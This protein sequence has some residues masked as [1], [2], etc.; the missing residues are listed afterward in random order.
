MAELLSADLTL[1]ENG[2]NLMHIW[3]FHHYA[4]GPGVGRAYGPYNLSREWV[5]S[6]HQVTL[7]LAQFHHLLDGPEPLA[8][9]QTIDGI[10]YVALRARSYSNNGLRRILNM[11]DYALAVLRLASRVQTDITA[12]DAIII[13]SPHPFAILP[14]YW[15]AHNF[16]CRL[17]FEVRD[18]WP[19]SITEL[20]G[21]SRWHPFV[22]L[23]GWAERFGYRRADVV[24]SLLAGV[25]RYIQ[26][27]GFSLKQYY[28]A[29]NG[30]N[31]DAVPDGDPISER[32]RK[33]AG[34]IADWKAE[35]RTVLTYAGTIGPPNGVELLIKAIAVV[36][37]SMPASRLGV[38]ILGAGELAKDVEEM[39]KCLGLPNVVFS[40][41]VPKV[42]ALS[43]ISKSDIGYA[44]LIP[45]DKLYCYGTS[46]NKM[47]DYMVC[48]LP[49]L[50]PVKAYRDPIRQS[51]GGIALDKASPETLADAIMALIELG[52]AGRRALGEKGRAYVKQHFNMRDIAAGYIKVLE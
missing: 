22:V 14:G 52:E 49:V 36:N 29:P 12:P 15:L 33:I 40:P 4:G 3:Y 23:C 45:H 44:G 37:S 35:G 38:L 41:P 21:T 10:R 28:W 6:G 19:L 25:D 7:F 8:G 50:F 43:L 9:D 51:G 30:V 39:A 2:P 47:M 31:L 17:V 18:L 32:G 26:D 11:F 13:S 48:G 1:V 16:N 20:L 42:E 46:L 5:K 34:L 27:I 24:V